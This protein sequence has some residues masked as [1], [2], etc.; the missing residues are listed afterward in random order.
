MK[1]GI[2]V[3]PSTT[4]LVR[5]IDGVFTMVNDPQLMHNSGD[6]WQAI[7]NAPGTV[8][9][10]KHIIPKLRNGGTL[11]TYT[12][13]IAKAYYRVPDD[14]ELYTWGDF[15]V[16]LHAALRSYRKQA[17]FTQLQLAEKTGINVRQIQ[18]L[19]SGEILAENMTLKNA[20]AL[21]DVLGVDVRQ[22]IDYK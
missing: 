13:P 5:C 3:L 21:A 16:E 22:L 12:R 17:G 18:K 4:L 19:E 15:G 6:K 8:V 9:S 7:I 1:F 20:I 2:Y 11:H 10:P 14:V